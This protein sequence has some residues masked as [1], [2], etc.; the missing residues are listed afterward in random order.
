MAEQVLRQCLT[1]AVP[2]I[3]NF[4]FVFRVESERL[5]QL[6]DLPGFHGLFP[7]SLLSMSF[8]GFQEDEARVVAWLGGVASVPVCALLSRMLVTFS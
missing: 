4:P 8:P 5:L 6:H 1:M 2:A 7:H 3:S